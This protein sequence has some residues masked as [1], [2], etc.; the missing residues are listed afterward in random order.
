MNVL[1]TLP[2]HHPGVGFLFSG[3]RLVFASVPHEFFV[4][5]ERKMSK[6]RFAVLVLLVMLIGVFIVPAQAQEGATI[7]AAACAEQAC[8][9][10]SLTAMAPWSGMKD[11][12]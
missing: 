3:V 2:T 8:S 6:R 9:A 7:P 5:R 1:V 11:E 4:L 12:G 10:R